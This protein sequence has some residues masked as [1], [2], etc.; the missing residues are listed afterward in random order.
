MLKHL[1]GAYRTGRRRG[2]WWKWK[3]DPFAI[4]AV[5]VYAQP[6]NGRRSNLFTDCTFAVWHEGELLPIAKAYSGLTD[7]EIRVLDQWV[8]AH[9]LQRF[10]PVRQVEPS[11]VFELYFEA[12]AESARHKSGIAVRFP[13]IGRWRTD[14][15]PEDADTLE[16]VKRLLKTALS[17]PSPSSFSSPAMV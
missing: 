5:L 16:D 10:G 11:L 4:Y 9:T 7:E 15:K 2:E 13:R 8:R 12:I 3:V 14:K 17:D 1:E 6:G